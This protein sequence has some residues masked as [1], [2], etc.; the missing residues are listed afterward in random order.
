MWFSPTLEPFD[1]NETEQCP[2]WV[3]YGCACRRNGSPR[4]AHSL[5]WSGFVT[6]RGRHLP[7]SFALG[8]FLYTSFDAVDGKQARRTGSSSPLGEL[9]DH[10]TLQPVV[11][12]T[13]GRAPR[14]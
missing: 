8:L 12:L 14:V 6:H 3:F 11:Q 7:S 9:F 2:P 4:P 13:Q 5:T 10:S 1:S